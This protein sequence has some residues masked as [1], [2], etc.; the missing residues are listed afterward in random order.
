[1]TTGDN[2]RLS[3]YMIGLSAPRRV[4]NNERSMEPVRCPHC[5][6]ASRLIS[7]TENATP[8]ASA[9]VVAISIRFSGHVSFATMLNN[10]E[11][12]DALR[13]QMHAK[14]DPIASVVASYFLANRVF[15]NPPQ[16]R[17][18]SRSSVLVYS[19]VLSNRCEVRG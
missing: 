16:V 10:S 6:P 11:A 1:M 7:T 12:L 13:R 9:A 3:D 18:E 19:D 4:R 14:H 17:L 5:Y 15:M 8:T 2:N